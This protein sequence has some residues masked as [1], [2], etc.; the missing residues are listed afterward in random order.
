MQIYRRPEDIDLYIGQNMELSKKVEVVLYFSSNDLLLVKLYPDQCS[1]QRLTVL[2]ENNL[3]LSGMGIAFSTLTP[4]C[5]LQIRWVYTALTYYPEYISVWKKY[6]N[7]GTFPAKF[8]QAS[9]VFS[10]AV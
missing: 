8:N 4:Q 5:L 7:V 2:C 9:Q 10:F 1:D 3:K 6:V